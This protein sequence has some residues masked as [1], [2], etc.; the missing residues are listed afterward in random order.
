[1]TSSTQIPVTVLTGFLGSGKTTLLNR[2]LTEQH[3]K[4]IAVIENE[5]GEIGIDNE[6]VI[7]ADEEIFEMNNGCICCTVRGDLIRILGNLMKR[8]DRLDAVLIETT[9]LAD[10]APVAQTFFVD[11]EMRAAF[12]LDAI[13]TMVDSKHVWQHL[14]TSSECQEQIAFA[15]VAILNKTDLVE[16]ADIDR[17]EARIGSM[18]AVARIHRTRDAAV[19]L[20]QI[21]NIRAFDLQNTLATEPDFLKPEMPF[22][23][24]GIFRLEPGAYELVLA[25]SAERHSNHPAARALANLA[26]EA[27]V[28]LAE[29]AEFQETAGRGVAARVDGHTILAGPAR[30][31]EECGVPSGFAESVDI[32]ENEGHSLI[33]IACDG[34]CIGWFALR[35]EVRPEAAE[36]LRALKDLGVRRVAMVTGDRRAVAERVARQIGCEEVVADCLPQDKV[37]YVRAMRERGYRVA[38]VGD[39]VNDA[40]ALAS[41]DLG[42]AM[43]AAGSEVAI[44]TASIALMNSD[45]R[46]LAFLVKIS[47][48][49]RSVIHQNFLIGV[50]F[51]LGGL[52]LAAVGY[53]NPIV[54]AIL[55]NAGSL[56]V[57]FN[58]ARLVRSGED[59]E[60]H[61]SS[62]AAS[63]PKA[64]SRIS[65][66]R[67]TP[68]ASRSPRSRKG[69][70]N[71][72]SPSYARI[73]GRLP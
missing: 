71:V 17:L 66:P 62:P 7:G 52:S 1:M 36:A 70:W 23:W 58:S 59:F 64:D 72:C 38:V 57:V 55:H 34:R 29:A 16:P 33:F 24:G 69:R 26:T 13:V 2:I 45:L 40:P 63:R 42:I 37:T 14:D 5:F 25:A 10:P 46:R 32:D 4:R 20:D 39:G 8:R 18:N 11:E 30:W 6:L 47:C 27:R 44:H 73:F 67:R 28:I 53:L 48:A 9:G 19:G 22:E 68:S 12:R 65:W 60:A 21:L 43:G 15:D 49:A 51:I 3:G 61:A 56:L 54:A 31:L 35:D 50:I 41:G